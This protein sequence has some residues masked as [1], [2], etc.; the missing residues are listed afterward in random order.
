IKTFRVFGFVSLGRLGASSY[1]SNHLGREG[2]AR[3]LE[4]T[5][6][7]DPIYEALEFTSTERRDFEAYA[8]ALVEEEFKYVLARLRRLGVHYWWGN[9]PSME[10]DLLW[11]IRPG[12]RF[13]KP[14]ICETRVHALKVSDKDVQGSIEE[15]DGA[16][17]RAY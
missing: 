17:S 14:V 2:S 16:A 15:V 3:K 7:Y 6:M 4:P 12:E 9:I 13:P 1:F 8:D 10:I 5:Q 11:K